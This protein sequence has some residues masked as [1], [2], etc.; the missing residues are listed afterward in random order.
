MSFPRASGILLH[1][2]SLPGPYGIGDLGAEAYHFA[3]FLAAA[4]QKIW[5]V[6]PLG[7]TGYGDSP[8]QCFSS[9]AGNPLLISLDLLRED[10]WLSNEDLQGAPSGP[11]DDIDYGAVIAFKLPLLGRA[12]RNFAV[13]AN[14][15]MH[16]FFAEFCERNA[17]WLDDYARF[18]A[19]KEAHGMAAWTHWDRGAGAGAEAIAARKFEQFVFFRQWRALK[20]YCNDRGIR[21]F[22]DL[23]IYVAHDS[24]DVWSRPDLFFLDADGNP[25][26]ASGVPPDYFSATGQLWGNPIYRWERMA[27]DGYAWW[28][29]RLRATLDMVDIVRLDHFRG[30]E[31]YWQVPGRDPTAEHG[32]WVQ[33][34]GAGLF[35]ELEKS[36][37]KLPI[38][39]ENLG[40]ITP[41]VEA[42]RNRFGY[43]GMSVLQFAFGRD[44]QAPDFRPH[45]Y[46]RNVVAYSG[47]HDNDTTVGWWNSAGIGDST[48]TAAEIEQEREIARQYL[49]FTGDEIHWAFIRALEASVAATVVI[50]MQD[51]L[52][53]GSAARM[54][55]PA[56]AGKNWRWRCLPGACSSELAQRLKHF[57]RLFDR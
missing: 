22:G 21:I 10:G 13:H 6:L 50:P 54:N 34:P 44:S 37:G 9:M 55:Q 31:A 41:E 24:A 1:P 25:E 15:A 42:I 39:A 2:S 11:P 45:N 52:G 48:R 32:K 28:A 43:P 46:P 17:S 51:V 47:T 27:A 8:Y 35:E 29:T 33:G 14:A 3:D 40:V 18:M 16:Q 56:T 23:P 38:V 20:Q 53:L 7:P 5:Q 4:G 36:L 30:F 57:A 19:L 26:F 49:N 12:Q